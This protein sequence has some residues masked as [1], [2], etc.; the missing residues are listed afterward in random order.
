MSSDTLLQKFNRLDPRAQD[1][2]L[3]FWDFLLT[4]SDPPRATMS[5]TY[6]EQICKVGVWTEEDVRT[7]E[8]TASRWHWSVP[9]W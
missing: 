2:L 5:E 1:Q 4:Q 8:D 7:L 3:A 9:E 6:R